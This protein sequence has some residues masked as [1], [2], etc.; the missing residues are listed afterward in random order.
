MV[1][2][3]KRAKVSELTKGMTVISIS[4]R[5][6][7]GIIT[8]IGGSRRKKE[9]WL[10][11]ITKLD[12]NHACLVGGDVAIYDTSHNDLIP[13]P[14]KLVRKSRRKQKLNVIVRKSRRRKNG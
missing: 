2:V 3:M 10:V 8:H 7:V 4:S 11:S 5:P 12:G 13:T 14:K 6:V 9:P 1:F